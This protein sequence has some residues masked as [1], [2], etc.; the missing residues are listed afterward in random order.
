MSKSDVSIL[1]L[2]EAVFQ[3]Y[4]RIYPALEREFSK[5]YSSLR[6]LVV[7]RG[8]RSL[9][10]DLCALAKHFDKCLAKGEYESCGG[11]LTKRISR[12][13]CAPRFLGGLFLLVFNKGGSLK[14]CPDV[15]AIRCIRQILLMCKKTAYPCGQEA[16]NREVEKLLAHDSTLPLP[17]ESWGLQEG[18]VHAKGF[19]ANAEERILSCGGRKDPARIG[20]LLEILEL[21]SGILTSTLGSYD[22]SEWRFRHGPGAISE[23][24]RLANKYSW[25]NWE[26][27]LES[28][29]PISEYGFYNH[30][31]W[32]RD[33]RECQLDD[34]EWASMPV[35]SRLVAVPKTV[36]A[37]RLIA[38]EPASKQWCQQNL[39][40]YFFG[41]TAQSW[42]GEFVSFDDQ[43]NNQELCRLGSSSGD[44]C[45]L[46]LRAASDSVSCEFVGNL[47]RR[48]PRLLRALRA[49]RT[50]HLNQTLHKG[51][52]ERTSLR[53]YSMMGSAV[54]FPIESIGFLAICLSGVLHQRGL[55][56]TVRSILNLIGEVS[57][58]GDDLVIPKDSWDSVVDLLEVNH[59][60]V[61]DSKSFNEGNFRESCGLDAFQGESI[62]PTY[63]RGPYTEDPEGIVS[64][65]QLHNHFYA[66]MMLQSAAWVRRG[67]GNFPDVSIRSGAVGLHTRTAFTPK[68]PIRWC[69]A[70]QV[71]KM[72]VM[73]ISS[74]QPRLPLSSDCAI[75]QYF[76]ESPS[77][78]TK[79][80]GGLQSR[81]RMSMRRRWVP[82]TDVLG[83]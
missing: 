80:K 13:N 77:P 76:T 72:R 34:D 65:I 61:N 47:F 22:P 59:F 29:F 66:K 26:P 10:I 8:L 36:D 5:D 52:Q 31:S 44:L 82:L 33:A 60:E 14:E 62:S 11:P 68:D 83:R 79:W 1:G 30:T 40:A 17:H 9:T 71:W 48:N 42:I 64:R 21:V 53:K 20:R 27:H 24:T 58:F 12:T 32:A 55:R 2:Y 63:W 19:N 7:T 3:D 51:V 28:E 70:H 25:S 46:D 81:V 56:P 39:L 15:Q 57:V 50:R 74:R 16:I 6:R 75:L 4:A 45:T 43:S 49:V 41:R 67:L 23:G 37:P 78:F 69:K 38:A 35:Q 73:T 18:D 54:T